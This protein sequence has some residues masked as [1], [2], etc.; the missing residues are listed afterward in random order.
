M[1]PSPAQILGK[2][3]IPALLVSDE[4]NVR[5]LTGLRLSSG[6]VLVT[7]GGLRLFVDGR[8]AEMANDAVRPGTDVRDVAEL[9]RFLSR[10]KMCG[11]ESEH[12][13]VGKLDRWKK[14]YRGTAFKKTENLIEWF[15]R[16]KDKEELQ[17]MEKAQR[18][19]ET[20]L[21]RA[22]TAA[23]TGV[24]ERGLAWK[25]E[26]WA[27]ELKAD[28]LAFDPIVAFGEHT[29]RPHHHPTDR[30]F[31]K[32]DIVLIDTGAKVGGY[33]AD[34][35]ATFFTGEAT[36]V[37]RKAMQAVEEAKETAKALVVAG[38]SVRELDRAARDVL[39]R[40]GMAEAFVHSL[41]HGVGLDI[42]EGVSLSE[43]GPDERLMRSEIVTIEPG[44]YFP[45]KFGIRLEDMVIAR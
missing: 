34:R 23:R 37:Q 16:S 8:Y 2:A 15:R 9:S 22:R 45:G 19:T 20:M 29:S 32:G 14:R 25:L 41:G 7:R 13:T 17:W 10:L 36:S 12:V 40:Y 6:L 24:T 33:C 27:R 5:Y 4:T 35:T 31:R 43:K 30:T 44:V 42:H 38:A 21:K 3:G 1:K 18:V 26:T 28:E 11:F 39:M